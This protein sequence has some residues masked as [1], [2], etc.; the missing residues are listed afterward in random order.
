MEKTAYRTNLPFAEGLSPTTDRSR[1]LPLFGDTPSIEEIVIRERRRD[2]TFNDLHARGDWA[3]GQDTEKNY[4]EEGDEYMLPQKIEEIL[5]RLRDQ[6][7]SPQGEEWV[8]VDRGNKT[9]MYPSH[10]IAT[11][12]IREKGIKI[13]RIFKMPPKVAQ[14]DTVNLVMGSCVKIEAIG[15]SG[16]GETGAAFCVSPNIF[17]TCAHCVKKYNKFSA[18]PDVNDVLI[19]LLRGSETVTGKILAM[20]FQKDLAFVS[21]QMDAEPLVLEA[22]EM[23]QGT[24]VV[25][26]GSPLGFENNVSS[27]IISGLN[28]TI[29]RYPG[30]PKY[31]FTDAN[32]LPGN[33]GGPMIVQETG[34]VAGMMAIIISQTGFYGL[35]AALPASY[36]AEAMRANRL[37]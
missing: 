4:H 36:I 14:V 10:E 24:H 12:E 2:R 21:A 22:E 31:I 11:K 35:N 9:Y 20:D 15:A 19:R 7:A 27:G 32:V 13:K 3:E 33:S 18:A 1:Q 34:K 16:A 25:V 26:V 28:R 17:A 37:G 8:V 30:A 5:I 23:G 6:G 29:F